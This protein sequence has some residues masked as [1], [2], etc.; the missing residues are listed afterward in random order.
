MY[1][2]TVRKEF[3]A[4]IQ[5]TSSE[6]R[7]GGS[8]RHHNYI[9]EVRVE[10]DATDDAGYLLDITRLENL[11]DGTLA[12]WEGRL[13]NELPEFSGE[14]PTLESVARLTC[15]QLAKRFTTKRLNA[16]QVTL[17]ES[18]KEP[19]PGPSAGYRTLLR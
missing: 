11:L 4:D 13:L 3:S 17:W 6:P 5:L 10:G 1:F 2:V 9:L 19:Y 8:I 15:S 7:G 18:E 16:I 12:G 14:N